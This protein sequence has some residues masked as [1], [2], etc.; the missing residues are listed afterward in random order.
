MHAP[1]VEQTE[2]KLGGWPELGVARAGRGPGHTAGTQVTAVEGVTWG[3]GRT[4]GTQPPSPRRSRLAKG[5]SS[6]PR[7][8]PLAP[9][10]TVGTPG[11]L[12][13]SKHL[14]H[15]L[16]DGARMAAKARWVLKPFGFRG[17]RS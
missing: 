8:R 3:W 11:F 13:G 12:L 7:Q 14:G 5:P 1:S 15:L 6:S 16:S 4:H 2:D 10:H 9:W 17:H